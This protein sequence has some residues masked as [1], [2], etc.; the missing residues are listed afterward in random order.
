MDVHNWDPSSVVH[1]RT[2]L[3]KGE[4]E[5]WGTQPLGDKPI[6]IT[7]I[8][9]VEMM[10][11]HAKYNRPNIHRACQ[12]LVLVFWVGQSTRPTGVPVMV[13]LKRSDDR[14]GWMTQCLALT[15]GKVESVCTDRT[16]D[17]FFSL[18]PLSLH[19]PPCHVLKMILITI[20]GWNIGTLSLLNWFSVLLPILEDWCLSTMYHPV[21]VSFSLSLNLSTSLW[22]AVGGLFVICES[23]C[24][25]VF[26]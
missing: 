24:V 5:Q 22:S 9:S 14:S 17:P 7:A 3:D 19:V 16:T 10:N 1:T 11:E 6:S 20:L 18:C 8:S 25:C 23:V 12:H 21:S 4:R 15:D 2:I 13:R 26:V